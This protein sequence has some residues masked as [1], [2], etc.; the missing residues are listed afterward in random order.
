MRFDL[1]EVQTALVLLPF[2]L[3]IAIWVAWSDMKVMKIPNTAVLAMA[4]VWPLVGW[5]AVPLNLWL[6]GFAIMAIVLA[7]G[8]VGNLA[9]LFGAGDAKFAAAI[10]PVFVGADGLFLMGLYAACALGALAAHRGM[11]RVPAFRRATPDWKSWQSA[12]FPFG[13]SLA[14]MVLFYL[15]AAFLP[16]G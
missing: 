1:P 15:L 3:P 14:G 5:L 4:A 8:F 9:G 13:L 7:A 10:A 11:K 16:Q 2:V 12:K 6:W